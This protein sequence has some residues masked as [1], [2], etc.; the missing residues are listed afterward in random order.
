MEREAQK[1]V[2]DSAQS[3]MIP[4]HTDTY[5]MFVDIKFAG[6]LGTF[7]GWRG[8]KVMDIFVDFRLLTFNLLNSHYSGLSLESFPFCLLLLYKNA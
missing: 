3:L 8:L 1:Q 6:H 2:G 5:K 7:N 4:S